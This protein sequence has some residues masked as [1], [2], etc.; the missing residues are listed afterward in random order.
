MQDCIG[1]EL[2]VGDIVVPTNSSTVYGK[3]QVI[4]RFGSNDK[5]QLNA[6]SYA[7]AEYLVK[8]T[9]QYKL[10][11]GEEEYLKCIEEYKHEFNT[12]AV[13]KVVPATRYIIYK[14]SSYSNL[15]TPSY[16]ESRYFCIKVQGTMQERAIKFRQEWR[17][18][19]EAHYGQYFH[20]EVLNTSKTRFIYADFAK[21]HS[22]KAIKEMNLESFI[23]KEITSKEVIKFLHSKR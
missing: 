11:K 14:A 3:V 12:E 6:S 13:K 17:P 10:A 8:I 5:V 9:E 21:D 4:T 7:K 2:Q 23:D 1:Q 19:L 16:K 18:M 22:L 15:G 20:A